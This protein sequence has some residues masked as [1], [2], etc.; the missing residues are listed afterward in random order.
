M[1]RTKSD[2]TG[3]KDT[4]GVAKRDFTGWYNCSLPDEAVPEVERLAAD[5]QS[6]AVEFLVLVEQECECGVKR[7]NDGSG[8][9][10]YLITRADDNPDVSVGLSAFAAS[11]GDAVACLVY[12]YN[13]LLGC[14]VPSAK[15]AAKRRFG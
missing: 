8:W 9:M 2:V 15:A 1:P 12:K 7:S 5:I 6:V 4:N 3:K 14:A 10:A 11:P 13:V